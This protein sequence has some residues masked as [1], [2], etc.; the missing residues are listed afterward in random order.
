[1]SV[2]QLQANSDSSRQVKLDAARE[3]R[4]LFNIAEG[5]RISGS[6]EV[7]VY[8]EEGKA[9]KLRARLDQFLRANGKK[10]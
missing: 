6:V 8:F 7:V 5:K 10:S 3:L 1:M 4:E 2:S 9:T